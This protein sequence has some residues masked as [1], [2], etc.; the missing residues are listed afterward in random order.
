MND[1]NLGAIDKRFIDQNQ[2]SQLTLKLELVH[3]R[4]NQT[5]MQTNVKK[6]PLMN[7]R[8]NRKF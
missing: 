8:T 1:Q 2:R 7:K 3:G 6:S 5:L 4:L